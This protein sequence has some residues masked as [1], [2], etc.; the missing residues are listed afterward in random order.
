MLEYAPDLFVQK[1]SSV[2]KGVHEK[3]VR[4]LVVEVLQYIPS[5][6]LHGVQ[7]CVVVAA[8]VAAVWSKRPVPR[9]LEKRRRRR[10][11]RRR[12]DGGNDHQRCSNAQHRGISALVVQFLIPSQF[13]RLTTQPSRNHYSRT[14]NRHDQNCSAVGKGARRR[15]ADQAR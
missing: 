12:C 3:L 7:R 13:G 6:I 11:R 15:V 5:Q 8:T 1:A 2:G 10:R 9:R 4:S 14:T